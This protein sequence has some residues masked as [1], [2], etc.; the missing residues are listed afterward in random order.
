MTPSTTGP[1]VE[2]CIE[3]LRKIVDPRLATHS[4]YNAILATLQSLRQ[5]RADVGDGGAAWPEDA[6]LLRYSLDHNDGDEQAVMVSRDLLARVMNTLRSSAPVTPAPVR[7]RSPDGYAY[8]YPDPFGRCEVI[9]FDGGGERNGSK[10]IEAVPYW[11][12]TEPPASQRAESGDKDAARFRWCQDN[13]FK[14]Q[15]LFWN[16]ASRRDRAKAIDA[17]LSAGEAGDAK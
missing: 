9:V 6:A 2:Q 7:E 11:L 1:T 15:A 17:A 4:E 10:P 5:P 3:W 16:H 8:R 14:A 13:P 12:G